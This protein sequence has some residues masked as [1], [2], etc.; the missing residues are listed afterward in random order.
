MV[1]GPAAGRCIRV[2]LAGLVAL[3]SLPV[4]ASYIEYCEF[5]GT[6][7]GVPEARSTP[8]PVFVVA[9]RV[10]AA[11]ERRDLDPVLS[12][13]E[14][15]T[16]CSEYVGEIERLELPR[17]TFQ[18]RS[19][20]RDGDELTLYRSVYDFDGGASVRVRFVRYR[21]GARSGQ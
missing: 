14:S 20:L 12:S 9:L 7:V 3:L 4:Q 19:R 10:Q 1:P 2:M 16:D 6:V 17:P 13:V 5:R 8:S 11:R 15:F 18:R 21:A